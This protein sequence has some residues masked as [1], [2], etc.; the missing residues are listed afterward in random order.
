M[1]SPSNKIVDFE[2]VQVSEVPVHSL[3]IIWPIPLYTC[4]AVLV[5]ITTINVVNLV[6]NCVIIITSFLIICIDH[7]QYTYS[8]VIIYRK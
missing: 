4:S 8:S 7:A 2:V 5:I 1:H 3:C 6:F